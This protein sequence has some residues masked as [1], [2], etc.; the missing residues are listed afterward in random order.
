VLQAR[1]Y[2][3]LVAATRAIIGYRTGKR[4]RDEGTEEAIPPFYGK[5]PLNHSFFRSF[6]EKSRA[7]K[8]R[9]PNGVMASGYRAEILPMICDVYL[10]A[11]EAGELPVLSENHIRA[12]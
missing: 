11:R 12:S 2:V 4:D 10:K 9:L 1:T 5:N 3:A 6:L 8:F 7:I